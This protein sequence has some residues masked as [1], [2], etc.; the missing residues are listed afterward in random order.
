MKV[1]KTGKG[2]KFVR[3][4]ISG[5]KYRLGAV[6]FLKA[7]EIIAVMIAV[8]AFIVMFSEP[9][10][11]A[12]DDFVKCMLIKTIASVIAIGISSAIAL[13]IQESF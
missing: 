7:I 8:L 6:I 10:A 1:E 12:F 5:R 13:R 11:Q 3:S 4:K 9:T 2:Q